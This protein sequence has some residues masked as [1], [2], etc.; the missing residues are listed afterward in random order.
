MS[1]FVQLYAATLSGLQ[2]IAVEVEV[3][4]TSGIKATIV[5]LPD[6]AVKIAVR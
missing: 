3:C 4:S 6:N 5:G 1:T 2:A